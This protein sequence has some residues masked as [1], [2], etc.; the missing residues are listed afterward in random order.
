MDI[1][2]MEDKDYYEG[3][4]YKVCLWNG[5]GYSLYEYGVYA[6]NEEEALNLAVKYAERDE[7]PVIFSYE[8]VENE[9]TLLGDDYDTIEDYLDEN[10]IYVDATMEG[11]N[12]P[13]FI[14]RENARIE[15]VKEEN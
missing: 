3:K 13:W 4:L 15:F 10:Y 1:L 2:N 14:L 5:S 6:N 11:A 8:E 7:D 12:E 9:Y